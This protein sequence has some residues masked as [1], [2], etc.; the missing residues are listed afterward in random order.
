MVRARR[1]LGSYGQLS[2]LMDFSGCGLQRTLILDFEEEYT[3][4]KGKAVMG[5]ATMDKQEQM[6]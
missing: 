1:Y 4:H 5:G 2:H 6:R 3:L